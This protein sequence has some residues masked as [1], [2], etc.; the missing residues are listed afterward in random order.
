MRITINIGF[1]TNSSSVVHYYPKEILE[2]PE[3][4][5][6]LTTYGIEGGYAS[7]D[8]L[9]RSSCDSMLLTDQQKTHADIQLREAETH[10]TVSAKDHANEVILIYGDEYTSITSELATLL[11]KVARR[12]G[13]GD[14]THDLH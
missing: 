9:Y 4:K 10:Y 1:I 13:M 7:D 6:F 5:F 3:V 14:Y 8:V 12:L 11:N 2:D